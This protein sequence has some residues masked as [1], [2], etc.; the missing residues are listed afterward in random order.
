MIVLMIVESRSLFMLAMYMLGCVC[1][2]AR[3]FQ[4]AE[5]GSIARERR[6][7]RPSQPAVHTIGQL[8]I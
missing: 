3:S 6:A 1:L 4:M 2:S 8:A 7:C 5:A